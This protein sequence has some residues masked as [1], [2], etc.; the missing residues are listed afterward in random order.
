MPSFFTIQKYSGIVRL[1]ESSSVDNSKRRSFFGALSGAQ[2]RLLV[3][4][5][6]Q[7]CWKVGRF[8]TIQRTRVWQTNKVNYKAGISAVQG[9]KIR[10]IL[11][12][13]MWRKNSWNRNF[14]QIF[15]H[16]VS[17]RL[18]RSFT[19]YWTFAMQAST[20]FFRVAFQGVVIAN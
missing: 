19:V 13:I 8:L 3:H 1:L 20:H 17:Q 14:F 12:E 18:V 11:Q 9:D 4:P 16:C 10:K 7:P 15:P 5:P 2:G 6:K